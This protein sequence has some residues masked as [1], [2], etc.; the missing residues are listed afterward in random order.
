MPKEGALHILVEGEFGA[1]Q[2][3]HRDVRLA[4]RRKTAGDGVGE[5]RRYQLVLKL[6]RTGG[7]MVQA[8]VAH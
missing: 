1:G 7:D 6:G 3:A 2:Q 4:D 8:I 5:L